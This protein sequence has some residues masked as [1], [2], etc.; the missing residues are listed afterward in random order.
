MLIVL[1][2]VAERVVRLQLAIK[3]L[4]LIGYTDDAV[5]RHGILEEAVALPPEALHAGQ[6][7]EQ[8]QRSAGSA[9]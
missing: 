1:T 8:G 7:G 3:V 2:G 6:S 9:A 4:Y 5:V